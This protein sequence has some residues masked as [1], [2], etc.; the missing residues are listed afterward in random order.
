MSS[1]N[2]F[3]RSGMQQHMLCGAPVSTFA[4]WRYFSIICT[5]KHGALKSVFTFFC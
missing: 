3:G 2:D 4:S 1:K 5:H